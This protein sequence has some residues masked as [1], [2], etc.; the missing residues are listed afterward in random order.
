MEAFGLAVTVYQRAV[1]SSDRIKKI[2]F[3]SPLVTESPA[4]QLPKGARQEI[5]QVPGPWRTKG[6]VEF[7]GLSFLFPGNERRVLD[8]INL[9][10]E[11][12][13]R[14]AFM[15]TI[16]SGK[17]SLFSLIPRLYPVGDGMIF[18]DDVDI[19]RWPVDELRRQIGYVSQDIYLFSERVAENIAFSLIDPS[20]DTE[21]DKYIEQAAQ[22]SVV[23]QEILGLTHRYNTLL[24]DRGVNLSG[25]QKQ[26]VT[27]ARALLKKPS[28][29]IMDDALSAV[30]VE[31]EKKILKGLSERPD[32]N[33]ELIS[34]HRIST[35][36]DADR[37]V[38]LAL[39]KIT[40]VGKH[41]ELLRDKIGLYARFYEQQRLKDELERYVEGL[42]V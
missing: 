37:I 30:D 42:N 13:E 5:N 17:S 25:G 16:G 34:A 12:G 9:K 10:I 19:N 14:V 7:R 38:V 6:G 4:T 33:T 35:I 28:I 26:R 21:R 23:H 1:A 36:R 18:V 3:E 39:G 2:L 29:L 20:A 40:Q 31:T 15:G 24:G 22:L 41:A 32:R 11:P 27:L 8:G